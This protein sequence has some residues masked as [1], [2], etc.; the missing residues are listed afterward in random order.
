VQLNASTPTTLTL[1]WP[2]A[3]ADPGTTV[4]SYEVAVDG[5]VRATV[6]A[7]QTSVQL[8]V[9]APATTY[10]IA[11]RAKDGN[12][13]VGVSLTRSLRT[14]DATAAIVEQRTLLHNGVNRTYRLDIP[15]GYTGDTSTR[16]VIGLHGGGGT[17]NGFA[18]YTQLPAAA[19]THGWV[20]AY[21]EGTAG[22][23]GLRTWNG[24]GCCGDSVATQVDDVGFLS[25]LRSELRARFHLT[26]TALTGH[27]NG[28]IMAYRFAC[29]RAG[30]VEGIGVYAGTLFKSPCTPSRPV[31]LLHIHGLLDTNLPF[32]GGMGS[33]ISG[34]AFPPVMPGIDVFRAVNGCAEPPVTTSANGVVTATSVWTCAPNTSVRLMTIDDANHEWAGGLDTPLAGTPSTKLNATAEIAT[35]INALVAPP[36]PGC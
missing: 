31:S 7:A 14:A 26:T 1:S 13:M 6:P 10:G 32:S 12:G 36:P 3:V 19:A 18:Y 35:F 22:P 16:L 20:V 5:V 25:A 23:S 8:T 17:P 9:L 30:E 34:V 21:P 33:G 11:V 27:S 29:E 2:A 4:T 24:G 15:A 28:A